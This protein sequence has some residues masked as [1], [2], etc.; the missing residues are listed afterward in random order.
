MLSSPLSSV[1]E[2]CE[3]SPSRISQLVA[4]FDSIRLDYRTTLLPTLSSLNS[5]IPT[6]TTATYQLDYYLRSNL[7]EHIRQPVAFMHLGTGGAGSGAGNGG[8]GVVSFS[9]TSEELHDML[10]KVREAV[11]AAQYKHNDE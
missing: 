2:D 8:S 4:F 6:L 9:A 1:L 7:A 10:A 3:W 5:T 11:R